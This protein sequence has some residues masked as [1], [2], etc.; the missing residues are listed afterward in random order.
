MS[1]HNKGFV[2]NTI[3]AALIIVVMVLGLFAINS[4][5]PHVTQQQRL[6]LYVIDLVLFMGIIGFL[7][8]WKK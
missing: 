2:G 5:P 4:L 7:I 1:T 8:K 3:I 6:M